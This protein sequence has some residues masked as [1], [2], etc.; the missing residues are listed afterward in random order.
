MF[1]TSLSTRIWIIYAFILVVPPLR[2]WLDNAAC[3]DLCWTPALSRNKELTSAIE[4]VIIMLFVSRVTITIILQQLNT[5]F[6]TDLFSF[7]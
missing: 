2:F 7:L 3:L 1:Q 4:G 6:V 5:L